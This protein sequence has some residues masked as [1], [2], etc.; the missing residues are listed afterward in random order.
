M[1]E[2][3]PGGTNIHDEPNK[4]SAPGQSSASDWDMN[5]TKPGP[6]PA[7]EP[8]DAREKHSARIAGTNSS[9]DERKVSGESSADS[10]DPEGL[11][12]GVHN[13]QNPQPKH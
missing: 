3:K 4:D 11:A 5:R 9:I 7:R 8:R 13:Q 12:G 2:R 6:G 1:A 10:D